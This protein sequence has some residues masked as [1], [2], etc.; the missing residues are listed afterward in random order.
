MTSAAV[1]TECYDLFIRVEFRIPFWDLA[2]R[3][4]RSSDVCDLVFE[5][6]AHIKNDG[7]LT[8]VKFFF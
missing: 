8:V 7:L 5:L 4:K 3:N 1:V 6:F 2:E